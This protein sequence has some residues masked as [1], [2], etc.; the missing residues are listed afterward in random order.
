MSVSQ[1]HVEDRLVGASNWSPWKARMVFFLE[2]LE[3]WDIV[4]A[5][6]PPILVTAPILVEEFRR[7]N[8]KAKSC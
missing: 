7:K 4:E 1:M 6:V 8:S 2:D 3:L 5:V